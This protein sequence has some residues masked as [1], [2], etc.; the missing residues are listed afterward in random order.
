MRSSGFDEACALLPSHGFLPG[1]DIY[2]VGLCMAV[3][4]IKC[5]VLLV[6][7]ETLDFNIVSMTSYSEYE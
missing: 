4:K 1:I 5:K 7:L 3:E 6:G 2:D